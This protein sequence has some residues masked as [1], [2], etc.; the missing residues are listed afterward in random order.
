MYFAIYTRHLTF[1]ESYINK[2]LDH[3]VDWI[4]FIQDRKLC[5]GT[6]EFSLVTHVIFLNIKKG[7]R[8]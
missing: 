2:N 6:Y 5:E 3:Y 8:Q 4:G 1:L 7:I